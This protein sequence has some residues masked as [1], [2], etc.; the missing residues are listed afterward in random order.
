MAERMRGSL[1]GYVLFSFFLFVGLKSYC[2]IPRFLIGFL[3]GPLK[4]EKPGHDETCYLRDSS[5]CPSY[6]RRRRK[7]KSGYSFTHLCRQKPLLHLPTRFP[8]PPPQRTSTAACGH[9]FQIPT[10]YPPTQA[11][12]RASSTTMPHS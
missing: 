12:A 3:D 2:A 6:T 1:R 11:L 7:L 5:R 10:P 8:V 9:L 4:H